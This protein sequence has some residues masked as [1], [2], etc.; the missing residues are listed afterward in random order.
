VQNGSPSRGIEEGNRE[1]QAGLS[2]PK[3]QEDEQQQ[4]CSSSSSKRAIAKP[5]S[6]SVFGKLSK[7]LKF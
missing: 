2:P 3:S 1:T 4:P 5:R 7:A 6:N